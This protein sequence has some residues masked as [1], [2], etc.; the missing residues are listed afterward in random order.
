MDVSV[1]KKASLESKV[2]ETIF[3][4]FNCLQESFS[5]QDISFLKKLNK[6]QLVAYVSD[7]RIN[8]LKNHLGEQDFMEAFKIPGKE[9]LNQILNLESG[10]SGFDGFE[11]TIINRNLD[12]YSIGSMRS[13][14]MTAASS[15]QITS[16]K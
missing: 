6:Y 14:R 4:T 13:P 2:F 1:W 9:E 12:K 7:A 16:M 8:M 3:R 5:D 15:N 10:K 11:A